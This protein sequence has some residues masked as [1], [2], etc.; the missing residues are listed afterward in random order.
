MLADLVRF[1]SPRFLTTPKA[2]TLGSR[3]SRTLNLTGESFGTGGAAFL[4]KLVSSYGLKAQRVAVIY[5]NSEYGRGVVTVLKAEL[6]PPAFDI[7]VDLPVTPPVTDYSPQ[8]LRIRDAKPD[9]LMAAQY[10]QDTVLTLRAMDALD[11]RPVFVGC[12]S[13]FSDSRLPGALT[14]D[15]AQRVL[16]RPVFGPVAISADIPYPPFQAFYRKALQA[17][18][19]RLGGLD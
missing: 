10:F 5:D 15:V 2:F 6:R 16:S 19:S 14:L 8:I 3:Y 11:Y 4:R 12:A 7:V 17:G 1:H 18:I 9:V 13:G